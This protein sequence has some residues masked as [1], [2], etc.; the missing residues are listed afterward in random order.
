MNRLTKL[1]AG[2]ALIAGLASQSAQATLV[3]DITS[4]GGSASCGASCDPG[5]TVG[6]SFHVNTAFN[7]D[8]LGVWDKDANGL[9]IAAVDVGLWNSTGTL[10]A[11]ATI[12][13]AGTYETS[14]HPAGDWLFADISPL[15]LAVGDY[16]IGTMVTGSAPIAQ[17]NATRTT[18]SEISYTASVISANGAG[19]SMPTAGLG[20]AVYGPNL[21]M[22]D[23][24]PPTVPEPESLA[25]LGIGLA[26]FSLAR[27]RRQAKA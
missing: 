15:F 27:T 19:F 16:V 24:V 22:A 26:A 11:S 17:T 12:T 1:A 25:L 20:V 2:L 13:S 3:M 7:V 21:R 6:W 5:T 8:G 9:G 4:G 10:L 18:I 23:T 14:A